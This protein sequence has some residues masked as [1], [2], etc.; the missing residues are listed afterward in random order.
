MDNQENLQPDQNQE[1]DLMDGGFAV[2]DREKLIEEETRYITPWYKNFVNVFFEP[3][4]MMEDCF[5]EEPPKGIGIGI[6]GSIIFSLLYVVLTIINPVVKEAGYDQLRMKGVA[7]NLIG[8]SYIY[9]QLPL[10]IGTVIGVFLSALVTAVILKIATLIAKDKAK[11]SVLYTVGLLSTMVSAAMLFIDRIVGYII[12]TQNIVLGATAFFTE[13]LT[14]NN[15]VLYTIASVF[16]I[17]S[18]WS[19]IITIIGYSVATN[20]SIKKG[21]I[22]MLIVEIIS[23]LITI[24]ATVAMAGL[25]AGMLNGGM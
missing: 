1:R 22:V 6:A 14:A 20:T 5:Y 11:F 16:T 8:Q 4:K 18:I 3:K 12:P 7:E 23:L 2:V 15:T 9:S 19:I 10:I 13:G 17:P 24:P 21:T 25:T